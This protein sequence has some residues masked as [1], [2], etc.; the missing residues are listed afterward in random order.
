MVNLLS[1][2]LG[3]VYSFKRDQVKVV[4]QTDDNIKYEMY[5]VVP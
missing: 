5:G 2:F 3:T 1:E 4:E